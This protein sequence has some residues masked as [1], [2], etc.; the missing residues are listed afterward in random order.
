MTTK[1]HSF[2]LA[3]T[4]GISLLAMIII[5]ILSAIFIAKGIDINMSADVQATAENMLGAETRLRATA[6]IGLL[7]FILEVLFGVALYYL[8]RDTN[9]VLTTWCLIVG[10]SAAALSM[11]GAMFAMNAAEFASNAAY[12]TLTN[13]SQRLMLSSLQA[14]SDYTSFHLSI[15]IS[16]LSKAGFFYLF[17]KSGFIPKLIAGWG[18]FASLFVVLAVVLRDFIPALANNAVTGA[19]MLCNMIALVSLGLYLVIKG[20]RES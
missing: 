4:A 20:I 15:V 8:L 12:T 10:I 1:S 2:T 16:S 19:F 18:V 5:G 9:P 3:R 14:T 11:L 6:Y 13:E 7:I 17:L